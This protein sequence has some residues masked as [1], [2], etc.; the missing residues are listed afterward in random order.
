MTITGKYIQNKA[1]YHSLIAGL[2]YFLLCWSV[3]FGEA[4]KGLFVTLMLFLPG[5]TFP[6]TT[7]SYR[8]MKGTNSEYS[9]IIHVVLSVVI[10]FGCVWLFSGEGRIDYITCLAGFSGSL[11]FL[12]L[13]KYLLKKELT[14]IQIVLTAIFSGLAFLPYELIGRH[15]ILL[16]LAVFL[17]TIINGSL[18]NF[19]NRKIN[20]PKQ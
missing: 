17:W 8:T 15:G 20:F 6:L 5:L 19:E 18:L 4:T 7:C 3:D 2:F 13:T 9:I 11:M 10:Y 12:L 14:I 16:G 1:F